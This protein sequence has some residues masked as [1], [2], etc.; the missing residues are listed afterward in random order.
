VEAEFTIW[1]AAANGKG[2][3]RL[4]IRSA[5][6]VIGCDLPSFQDLYTSRTL[7]CATKIVADPGHKL[8]EVLPS[9]RRLR[10]LTAQI[11]LFFS[12]CYQ[13]YQQG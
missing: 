8:F 4:I 9:G 3:S 6:R 1:Y 11:L 5:G 7:K 13:P 12:D 2:L 10:T